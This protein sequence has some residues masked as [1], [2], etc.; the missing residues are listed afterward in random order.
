[1]D[2]GILGNNAAGKIMLD[3]LFYFLLADWVLAIQKES[4]THIAKSNGQSLYEM[5]NRAADNETHL[6]NFEVLYSQKFVRA[7]PLIG[8]NSM[9]ESAFDTPLFGLNL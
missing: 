3:P 7:E 8:V 2:D 5:T 9:I 1:M 6:F 4:V